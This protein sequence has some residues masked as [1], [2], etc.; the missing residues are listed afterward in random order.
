[1]PPELGLTRPGDWGIPQRRPR[2]LSLVPPAAPDL[3]VA[4]G[5][6]DDAPLATASRA[7]WCGQSAAAPSC[8]GAQL[9]D[10]RC[11]RDDDQQIPE[12]CGQQQRNAQRQV[13]VGAEDRDVYPA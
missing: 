12:N 3:E 5:K 4:G 11:S 2:H 6:A 9:Q 1:M 13:R 10:A 8:R 7:H